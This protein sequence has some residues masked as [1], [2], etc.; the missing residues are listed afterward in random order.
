[1]IRAV[2]RPTASPP[3]RELSAKLEQTLAAGD[4]AFDAGDRVSAHAAYRE[5]Q[6]LDGNDPGVLS[7]LGL[8]LTLVGRDELKGVA[9][10]EEAIRRGGEDPDALWRLAMV[11]LATFQKERAIR[12]IRRGLQVAPRHGRLVAVIDSLGIRRTPVIPFLSRSNPLNKW[13]GKLRHRLRPMK[14]GTEE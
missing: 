4:A 8:T 10:C 5:A 1:M 2:P 9:F 3:P 13:L 11:Y 6:H 14:A 12:T 7:R